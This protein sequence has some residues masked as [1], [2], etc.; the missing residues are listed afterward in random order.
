M[1]LIEGVV[2][3]FNRLEFSLSAMALVDAKVMN[4]S[5]F[6]GFYSIQNQIE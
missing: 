6:T 2:N 3:S 4:K 5:F 1:Y